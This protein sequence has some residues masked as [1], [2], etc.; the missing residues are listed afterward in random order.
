M[1]T[2]AQA[3]ILGSGTS[4]GVPVIGCAC[5]VCKSTDP[6]DQRM[7]SSLLL[8]LPDGNNLVIDT[9]PD[10]RAQML[11]AKVAKLEHVLYTHTHADH[12]HGFD[13]LRAFHF[14]GQNSVYCYV[15]KRHANEFRQKFA[16]A[17][18]DTGYIGTK[19]QV[20]LVEFDETPFAL[21]GLEVEPAYA[22]HGNVQSAVF[23]IGRFAYATD[24]KFFS[25]EL[26]ARWRGKIDTMV[27]SGI[28]YGDHPTHSC[29]QQTIALMAALQVKQGY[30]THI[31]HKI[32]HARDQSGL[33]PGISFA[34]DGLR[35][36]VEL[37]L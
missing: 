19:L 14:N 9:G 22:V 6:F 34:Y 4:T 13:D 33:P 15:A 18:R 12:C 32:M 11:H 1:T 7:R 5:L 28:H 23:R 35:F 26:I 25:P 31:S 20:T 27:A 21:L 30:I 16:Y 2:Q 17:F 10:F 24:F 36:G 8:T 29:I 3:T 37:S